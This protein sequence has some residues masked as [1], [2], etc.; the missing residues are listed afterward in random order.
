MLNGLQCFALNMVKTGAES[1]RVGETARPVAAPQGAGLLAS[2]LKCHAMS[3]APACPWPGWQEITDLVRASASPSSN[4]SPSLEG[5]EPTAGPYLAPGRAESP[6]VESRPSTGDSEGESRQVQRGPE[7]S[8]QRQAAQ[9]GRR[10]WRAL[11]LSCA[12]TNVGSRARPRISLGCWHLSTHLIPWPSIQCCPPTCPPRR[13]RPTPQAGGLPWQAARGGR[14]AGASARPAGAAAA[15][16]RRLATPP[17]PACAG[18]EQ[19]KQ[20]G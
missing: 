13:P 10:K 12:R 3:C 17:R 20:P 7:C 18:R 9:P 6:D 2:W 5:P 8:R 1:R 16:A 4:G 14:P 11:T 15:A 19:P